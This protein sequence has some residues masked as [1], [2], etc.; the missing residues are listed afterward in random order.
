MHPI[1]PPRPIPMRRSKD[2]C[3][4]RLAQQQY[5]AFRQTSIHK[6]G[7]QDPYEVGRG[8]G[9]IDPHLP[10]TTRSIS[11]Y[12]VDRCTSLH[13]VLPLPTDAIYEVDHG[14]TYDAQYKG[15]A[16]PFKSATPRFA[17][18]TR[19]APG[20]GSYRAELFQ[21]A[22][23]TL[24][25]TITPRDVRQE[26]YEK[27]L[28]LKSLMGI[29]PPPPHQPN[30]T[31]AKD[32]AMPTRPV[33]K[34]LH[35][36]TGRRIEGKRPAL[37]IEDAAVSSKASICC[38]SPLIARLTPKNAY[39]GSF[40]KAMVA[41]P[42]YRQALA[43]GK[44]P[45]PY[46]TDDAEPVVIGEVSTDTNGAA[47]VPTTPSDV[48]ATGIMDTPPPMLSLTSEVVKQEIAL[49]DHVVERDDATI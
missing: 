6:K 15:N 10:S 18:S 43:V 20:P 37:E 40:V 26:H 2:N 9:Y 47:A 48:V 17:E 3:N 35:K 41:T 39:N 28:Q 24:L 30:V 5:T 38:S 12:K 14:I 34:P 49:S 42:R 27:Q 36:S 22:F 8:P 23:P 19:S 1:S 44:R 45:A 7:F 25:K 46:V 16:T 33:K 13:L 11:L 31:P 21:G 29:A 32:H 4:V